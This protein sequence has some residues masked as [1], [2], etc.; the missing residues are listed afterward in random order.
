VYF[1]A[2]HPVWRQPPE[3]RAAL[4]KERVD[5]SYQL[6][7]VLGEI[8]TRQGVMFELLCQ[9]IPKVD[10]LLGLKKGPEN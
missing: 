4:V 1:P 10:L 9:L 5:I 3:L 8:L 7:H 2:D 6:E